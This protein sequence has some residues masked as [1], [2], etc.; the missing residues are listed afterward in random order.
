MGAGLPTFLVFS[1]AANSCFTLSALASVADFI[2]RGG[3]A[4]NNSRICTSRRQ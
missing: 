4:E 2:G 1:F 3:I